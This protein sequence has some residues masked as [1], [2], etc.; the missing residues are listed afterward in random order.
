MRTTTLGAVL[1]SL[2]ITTGTAAVLGDSPAQAGTPAT[3]VN[4]VLQLG[5]S[6][7]IAA[8]YRKSIGTFDGSVTY[9][10][11]ATGHTVTAGKADLQRKLPG[12]HWQTVR[13]DQDASTVA[14]GTYGSHATG[15]MQY[16]LHYLGGTDGTTTW[17]PGY[18]NI[19]T[20]GTLWNLHEHASC[21]GG[22]R[23]SG[24]LSPKAKNVKVRIEVAKSD[25]DWATYKTVRTDS[26]SRWRASVKATVAGKDYRPVALGTK[27]ETTTFGE[28]YRFAR[29]PGLRNP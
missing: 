18:S 23:L 4:V 12:K 19:I 8:T 9:V 26:R 28:A 10:A 11:D 1:A 13:T 27:N 17:A 15:N 6:S 29:G 3:P 7:D 24:R 20:V 5:G 25:G 16:R 22:C 14:F 21:D 2:A